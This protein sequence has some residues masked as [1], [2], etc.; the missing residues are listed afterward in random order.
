MTSRRLLSLFG[1]TV[2][3]AVALT[4]APHTFCHRPASVISYSDDSPTAKC[5]DLQ[6][7][8]DGHDTVV[9]TEERTIT[10]SEAPLLRVQAESNGGV[11][12][13]GWDEDSYSVTL[14]KAAEAG[15]DADSTLSKIHLTFQNGELGVRGPSSPDRWSAHLLI[16]SP[17]AAAL[18]LHVHNGPLSLHHVDGNVKLHAENGPV[19]VKD[20][21]GELDLNSHNGPITLEGN[22]GKQS[23][24]TEN[25]PVTVSLEGDSWSGSGLEAHATNGPVTLRIPSGYKSGVVIESDGHGPFHCK[26]SLCSEGRKTWEGDRKRIEF[27]SGP[28]LIRISTVNGPLSVS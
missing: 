20:C 2:W 21:S 24:H 6:V 11:Q 3:A 14:C 23:V 12:V 13:H 5:S 27:G 7:R 8:F 9:Q 1:I 22:S 15:S 4:A 19:T 16:R 28:T 25:G 10:R 26:A 17:K 18:D